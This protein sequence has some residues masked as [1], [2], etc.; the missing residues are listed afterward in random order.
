[1]AEYDE[2]DI[3]ESAEERINRMIEELFSGVTSSLFDL[4]SKC[5]KPLYRIE[6]TDDEVIVTFD[7]PCVR[8][9]DIEI[10]ST[11]DTL[12]INA[13]MRKPVSIR[14]GGPF[15]RDFEFERYSKKIRLPV[16]VDP[17][18][19]RARFRNG[20]LTI[21]YPISRAGKSVEIT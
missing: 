1:M 17:T 20:I 9:E 5:L 6:V 10:T 13:L 11:E 8:K 3:I 15:Q 12:S 4:D 21:R 18:I 2:W 16:K 19:A 14:V 7:L